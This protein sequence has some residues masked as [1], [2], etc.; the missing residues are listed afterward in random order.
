LIL[1]DKDTKFLG[2]SADILSL[3]GYEDM[4]AF[5]AYNNDVADLF[6][7]RQGYVHKFDNFS[8]INY[9]Q[10]GSM[11]NKNVI[12][13]TRNGA[14]IEAALNITELYLGGG[15]KN[16]IV[17]LGNIKN[18]DAPADST[19]V[20]KKPLFKIDDAADL[21]IDFGA[22]VDIVNTDE[23]DNTKISFSFDEN[24]IAKLDSE[25]VAAAAKEATKPAEEQPKES[26]PSAPPKADKP[27]EK[28]T[29]EPKK[30][31][32]SIDLQEIAELLGISEADVIKYLKEYSQ[33]LSE[34]ID[35][36]K[37][38]YKSGNTLEA[39]KLAINVI[40][41]GSNLR[42]KEVVGAFQKLMTVGA[43]VHSDTALAEIDTVCGAFADMTAKL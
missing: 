2:V 24:D 27:K 39:R 13:K 3:L 31:E 21:K 12:V 43:G 5:M 14:E 22:P 8:W 1:Y 37:S 7:N 20:D 30:S 36:I 26:P 6:V 38:M 35:Q 41:I 32:I 17:T 16:Y 11:P 29:E 15:D 34:N 28:K 42:A 19:L 25:S 18:I 33:Y 9:L 4:N 40:G 10:N 23:P